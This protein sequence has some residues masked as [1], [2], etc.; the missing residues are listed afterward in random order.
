V[1]DFSSES[2]LTVWRWPWAVVLVAVTY[3]VVATVDIKFGPVPLK[4]I[5]VLLALCA[6]LASAGHIQYDRRLLV[7]VLLI[8][9]IIPT[10]WVAVAAV[11]S[12]TDDP[13][14]A[15]GLTDAFEQASRFSYVLLAVP[16]YDWLCRARENQQHVL[17]LPGVLALC[18]ITW[19]LFLGFV[20]GVDYGYS[21]QVGPFKGA[22]GSTATGSFRAFLVNHV[23]V[24]PATM[25]VLSSILVR[26]LSAARGALLVLL[27]ST[28]FL[29]HARGLW[30]GLCAGTAVLLTLA[31]RK[32][33]AR[34]VALVGL[35]LALSAALVITAAPHVAESVVA[36]V[37]G[38]TRE[39]S[40]S[41]RLDQGPKLLAGFREHA[42]VGSG[43]G[44]W[45]PTGYRRSSETP[46]SFEL[47]YLQ[48]LFQLGLVGVLCLAAAMAP[49]LITSW[50]RIRL[51]GPTAADR[52]LA[53][54][55]LSSFV[56]YMLTCAG[57]P[58]LTTSVGMFTL[59]L[60]LTF[61]VARD[62]QGAGS[63]QTSS[64]DQS[65][66][67]LGAS[68]R[69]QLA[70]LDS[71]FGSRVSPTR[72]ASGTWSSLSHLRVYAPQHWHYLSRPRG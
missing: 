34:R 36:D 2:T 32:R 33:L 72:S 17:W 41:T 48:L 14:Q 60:S 47:V 49:V 25:L 31:L 43:L 61:C 13:A 67:V 3:V 26:G 19:I 37:T 44:A 69:A 8:G 68:L 11:R 28:A 65:T 20:F 35:V 1:S 59:A 39:L 38:G 57:N 70:S 53:L 4:F 40:T 58:Y 52:L 46:W 29:A 56:G 12:L 27:L 51:A 45:L 64:T 24:I 9:V 5:L 62:D 16:V 6:W 18:L 10:T 63:Q 42:V 23:V 21:G 66:R 71:R 54:A 7:A 15:H 55:G 22:I 30:I 50:H